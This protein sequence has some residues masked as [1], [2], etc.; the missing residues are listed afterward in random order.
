MKE[1]DNKFHFV[2][3]RKI[4][5]RT[6]I[7]NPPQNVGNKNSSI[8][9]IE[10]TLIVDKSPNRMTYVFL[11]MPTIGFPVALNLAFGL[12]NVI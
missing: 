6:K 8:A 5:D 7:S 3:S 4:G 10:N 12:D 2:S 9:N 11:S 1:K